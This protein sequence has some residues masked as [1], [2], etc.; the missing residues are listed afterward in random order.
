MVHRQSKRIGKNGHI[1]V[2]IHGV[3]GTCMNTQ[4][5]MTYVRIWSSRFVRHLFTCNPTWNENGKELLLVGQ[6][7]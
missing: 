4:D 1:T 3:H 6:S 7:S 2:Y 5:A